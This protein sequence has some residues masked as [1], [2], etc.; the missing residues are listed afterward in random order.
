M[1][2]DPGGSK[3]QEKLENLK[4]EDERPTGEQTARESE[5]MQ[6]QSQESRIRLNAQDTKRFKTNIWRRGRGGQVRWGPCV[7]V[8][9]KNRGTAKAC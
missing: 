3:R 4:L 6:E 7:T 9:K 2:Y 5:V 8:G 1:I